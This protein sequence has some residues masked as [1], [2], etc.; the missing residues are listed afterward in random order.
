[1]VK[2][3]DKYQSM[4]LSGCSTISAL[5]GR[6]AYLV[7]EVAGKVDRHELVLVI[8]NETFAIAYFN[9]NNLRDLNLTFE[10]N[11]AFSRYFRKKKTE[12]SFNIEPRLY[13]IED[14]IGLAAA[15]AR[16][17]SAIRYTRF[18]VNGRKSSLGCSIIDYRNDT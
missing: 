10:E 14:W 8:R 13:E 7:I 9:M 6:D 11:V 2:I 18:D 16:S 15:T 1:M 4:L 3:E 5:H 12:F 17:G